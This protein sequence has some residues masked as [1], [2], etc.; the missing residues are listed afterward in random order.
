MTVIR[1]VVVL[2][3]VMLYLGGLGLCYALP[4][5]AFVVIAGV[6]FLVCAPIYAGLKCVGYVPM[7]IIEWC[8]PDSV[9]WYIWI[10]VFAL[11]VALP[12]LAIDKTVPTD[13]PEYIPARSAWI[14]SCA[15]WSF[16]PM[17]QLWQWLR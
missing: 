4:L 17:T 12:S 6:S 10:L 8:T 15:V 2:V 7:A 1:T 13:C 3:A 14:T 9:S 5:Y 16:L 11:G